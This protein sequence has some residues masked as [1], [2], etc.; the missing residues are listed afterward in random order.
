MRILCSLAS[1]LAGH[2]LIARVD[3]LP[4]QRGTVNSYHLKRHVIA[5]QPSLELSR[6]EYEE[7]LAARTR[8]LEHLAVEELFDLLMGNYEEFERELL[9]I[10]SSW[11]T[12]IGAREEWID[13]VDTVHLVGRRFA[14]LLT[15]NTTALNNLARAQKEMLQI[16]GVEV[17]K[18][19]VAAAGGR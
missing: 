4:V 7:L 1:A 6:A 19:R 16:D 9:A 12:F 17:V 5:R 3:R 18:T 10:A 8:V 14:N 2:R 15:P 11:A 13:A